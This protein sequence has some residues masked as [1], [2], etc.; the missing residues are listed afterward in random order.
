[1]F[2]GCYLF[3]ELNRERGA[4]DLSLVNILTNAGDFQ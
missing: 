1:M 2:G 4:R 3:T